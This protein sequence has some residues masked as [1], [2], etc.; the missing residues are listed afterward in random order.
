MVTSNSSK[1][2]TVQVCQGCGKMYYPYKA[3]CK[4]G[5]TSFEYTEIN[6]QGKVLTYTIIYVPPKGFKPPLKVALVE[7]DGG[8]KLLGRYDD[9]GEPRIGEKVSVELREGIAFFKKIRQ[10]DTAKS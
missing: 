2:I 3:R 6:P 10:E 4:C 1:A 7:L 5:S 9:D 8:L